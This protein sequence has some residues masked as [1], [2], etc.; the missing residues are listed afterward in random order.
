MVYKILGIGHPRTGTGYTAKLLQSWGLS[1]GHEELLEDGIV[2][3]QFI[4][5][6]GV[7]EPDKMPWIGKIK[8]TELDFKKIIYNVRDPKTSIPSIINTENASLIYRSIWSPIFKNKNE[9]ENAI[10][11]IVWTDLRINE[12]FNNPLTYRVE[13]QEDYLFEK[14]STE[15]K[16]KKDT[17]RPSKNYNKKRDYDNNIDWS[18]VRPKYRELINNFSK[19]YGYDAIF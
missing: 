18:S 1:V 15:F 7:L 5:P 17:G 8:H 11:S 4:I 13:D 19:R 16:L 2:A 10:V 3:W 14:L 9:I 12:I 6:T